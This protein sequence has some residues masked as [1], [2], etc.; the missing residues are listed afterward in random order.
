VTSVAV[1]VVDSDDAV[2]DS[3]SLVLEMHGWQVRTYSTGE[4]F[5]DDLDRHQ[6]DCI[7]LDPH[8]PGLS[9]AELARTVSTGNRCIPIIALTARPT[10]QLTADT[11]NAGVAALLT[12]PVSEETLVSSIQEALN[13]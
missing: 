9:G 7:V 5:L 13:K 11:V 12:K 4:S 6:P 8:L 3:V 10:S 2:L 1:A